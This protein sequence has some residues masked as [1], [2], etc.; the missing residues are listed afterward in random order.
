MESH[1]QTRKLFELKI[2][3]I[4]LP[5]NLNMFFGA[6]K[7]RL[8]ETVLLSTHNICFGREIKKIFFN[9]AVLFGDPRNTTNIR[10]RFNQVPHLTQ[11]T[12]WESDKNTMKHHKQGPRGQPFPSSDHKAAINRRESM[13]NTRHK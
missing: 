5:I 9:Y 1:V 11:D 10:N 2:V 3:N 7:N 13:T 12:T 8:I 6:Q 4:F